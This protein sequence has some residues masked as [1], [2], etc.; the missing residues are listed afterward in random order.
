MLLNNFQNLLLEN[1]CAEG[2]SQEAAE[3][4]PLSQP[5]SGTYKSPFFPFSESTLITCRILFNN[6]SS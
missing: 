1:E 4:I 6:S 5:K 3:P 2:T